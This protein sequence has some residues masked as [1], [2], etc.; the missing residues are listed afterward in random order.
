MPGRVSGCRG[1]E[2]AGEV[3]CVAGGGGALCF[4]WSGGASGEAAQVRAVDGF[5][6]AHVGD[7]DARGGTSRMGQ[8]RRGGA[9]ADQRETSARAWVQPGRAFGRGV[10]RGI[11]AEGLDAADPAYAAAGR[12]LGSGTIDEF[13]RGVLGESGGGWAVGLVD[14]RCFHDG[15]D[16]GGLCRDFSGGGGGAGAGVNVLR[17]VGLG[18]DSPTFAISG[19]RSGQVWGVTRA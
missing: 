16:G 19:S 12:T 6:G 18:T 10:S 9:G 13:G 7:G 14:R 11:G 15:R 8:G 5:G 17:R 4:Y 2:P 3:G 1:G